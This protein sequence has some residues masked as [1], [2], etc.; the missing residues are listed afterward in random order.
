[1][2]LISDESFSPLQLIG[3]S[4]FFKMLFQFQTDKQQ[5]VTYR[6]SS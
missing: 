3:T 5:V 6:I 2:V 4:F 1:M